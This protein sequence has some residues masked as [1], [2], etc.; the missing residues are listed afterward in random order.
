M[1][2]YAILWWPLWWPMLVPVWRYRIVAQGR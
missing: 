1:L 2:T